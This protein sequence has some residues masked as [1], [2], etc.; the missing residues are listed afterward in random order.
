MADVTWSDAQKEAIETDGKSII[1]S[2]AAGSGKTSVLVERII[3]KICASQNPARVD[4]LLVVTFT[5]AAANEMRTR[6]AEA[7]DKKLIQRPGDSFLMRQKAL[8]PMA[9]ICNMDRFFNELVRDNFHTL[10]ITPDYRILDDSEA[11]LLINESVE[12]ALEEC[13]DEGGEAFENLLEVVGVTSDDYNLGT[14]V[15]KINSYSEAFIDP[16]K[17]LGEVK[18]AYSEKCKP[19]DTVF[20]RVILDAFLKKARYSLSLLEQAKEYVTDIEGLEKVLILIQNEEAACRGLISLCESND[21]DGLY[22]QASC[23]KF[24]KFPSVGNDYKDLPEK[25]WAQAL[26][27]RAKTILKEGASLVCADSSDFLG[28]AERLYPVTEKLMEIVFRYREL[29]AEKKRAVNSM[30]FNDILH[31]TVKLLIKDGKPTKMAK[32][33]SEG[34]DEIFIDEYQDTNEAQDAVF[35]A[36]SR[37]EKN[38]FLVGDIKQSIYRFRLAM[39]RLFLEKMELWRKEDYTKG[40][41]VNLDCNYRSRK[42]VL[43]FVNLT[44]EGTMSREVGE[45]NYDSEQ[46]LKA[47]LEYPESDRCQPEIYLLEKNSLPDGYGEA[48][49]IADKIEHILR[50]ETVYDSKKKQTRPARRK[51]ICVLFRRNAPG[52]TLLR[53]LKKRELPAFMEAS[54]GFFKNR[55]VQTVISLLNIIDNPL[56]DIHLLNVLMSPLYGFNA[57]DIAELRINC[58]HGRLFDAV[59]TAQDEKSKSFIETYSR[60]RRLSTVLS[61]KALIRTV[62]E[63]TGYLYAV[64]AQPNGDVKR[65]NLLLLLEY[66]SSYESNTSNGLSGFMRYV[67]SCIDSDSE[68]ASA[69]GVSENADVVKIMTIHKSKGLEFPFVI[70]G[71]LEYNDFTDKKTDVKINEDTGVGIKVCEK[72]NFKKYSTVQYEAAK[73]KCAVSNCSEALRIY[74]VAMTRAKEKLIL[75]ASVAN[76]ER[77][78]NELAYSALLDKLDPVEVLHT[79][80]FLNLLLKVLLKHKDFG[81]FRKLCS[82]D[83]PSKGDGGISLTAKIVTEPY[84]EGTDEEEGNAEELHADEELLALLKER[85]DY[86]YPYA[87]LAELPT[88]KAASSFNSSFVNRR[89][90]AGSM[91]D[92]ASKSGLSSAGRGTATHR[93]MEVCDFAAAEKD[94][95]SEIER[96]VGTGKLSREQADAIDKESVKAFFASSLYRRIKASDTVLREYRFT[97]FCPLEMLDSERGKLFPEEKILVQG[98]IDCAFAE[99]GKLVVLDYKT[100]NVNEADTLAE[101]YKNQLLVYKLAAEQALGTEVKELLLYSFKLNSE[102]EING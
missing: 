70:V 79:S 65:L 15:K 45:I 8:L 84:H 87:V 64:S 1:V 76:A 85:T 11:K 14:I 25:G 48:Q 35:K 20:G 93:L 82:V 99:D 10:G 17:W 19:E 40:H 4:R 96:L 43:D 41:F 78:V 73:E 88:K 7:I 9:K 5:K 91:P 60:Y 29:Y 23:L 6:L 13:Y 30:D 67:Q 66:A 86:T 59:R 52:L 62:Y 77:R 61:V 32:E 39:P 51:D 55:E 81:D 34:F 42:S 94:L 83:I 12:E 68:P 22:T 58:R 16:E 26:R 49:F 50:H 37:D 24:A 28:D 18:K 97:V 100:D 75:C 47:G 71:N 21:W 89:Y 72:K 95:P 36:L 53:E 69:S 63:D 27:D 38:L 101:M 80:C 3:R 74:Y 44:F 31:L 54:E 56:Q 33:L 102:I 57:D 92:F 46:S 2:A 98:V 90:F